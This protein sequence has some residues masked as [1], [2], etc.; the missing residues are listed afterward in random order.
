M[1]DMYDVIEIEID[2]EYEVVCVSEDDAM[3]QINNQAQAMKSM[4]EQDECRQW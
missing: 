2:N 4:G 1:N 3:R